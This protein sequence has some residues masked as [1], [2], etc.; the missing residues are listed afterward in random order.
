MKSLWNVLRVL[1]AFTGVFLVFAAVST[2]DYY[3]FELG[4]AEPDYIWKVVN[5][6]IVL[7][8]PSLVHAIRTGGV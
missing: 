8:A 4:Q 1:M 5:I 3:I 2:S 6:G 7:I